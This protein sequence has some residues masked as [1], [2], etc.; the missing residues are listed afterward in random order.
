MS[1]SVKSSS[2][3]INIMETTPASTLTEKEESDAVLA[4]L[5]LVKK[6]V[7]QLA[8]QASCALD[9]Q[10]IE[11]IALMGLLEAIRRYGRP[12][13]Q[14]GSYAKLRIRGAILDELRENDWR[15]RRLRQKTHKLNDAVRALARR[16]GREPTAHEITT[17]LDL[18]AQ[19]YQQYLLLDSAREMQSLDE[20]LSLGTPTDT[21]QSRGLEEK[22]IL[23]DSMKHALATL[24]KREQIILS[25]Y[26][27][28]D[29]SLKEIA[30][31]LELTEAR[32]CQLNKKITEKIKLFYN[33][34][35]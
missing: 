33:N 35:N 16:L 12:D 29:M 3:D 28:H 7:R 18:T 17:Q 30:L 26:Y 11:Q 21:L 1:L 9:I 19:E 5:P 14:F 10:D 8:L 4:Y 22:F 31:T 15:P 6:I 13:G 2:N 25:L 24:D 23:Q 20:L 32:V 34:E 27:Q